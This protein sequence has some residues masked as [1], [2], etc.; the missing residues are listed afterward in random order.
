MNAF[1]EEGMGW[2]GAISGLGT[3]AYAIINMLLAQRRPSGQQTG[4]ARQVLRTPYLVVATMAFIV[5]GFVLWKQLPLHLP[6]TFRLGCSI[7]GEI[8]LL[9][10]LG[11]Y[12]WGLRNLGKNFNASS[13]FGVRLKKAHQLLTTGPF[14]YVRYPIYLAVILASWSGLMLLRTRTMLMMALMMF[15]LVY[16]GRKE[17][18]ALAQAFG[19]EWE[20][21]K[22]TVPGWLPW[23][24]IGRN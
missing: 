2:L 20:A 18:N 12:I 17:E 13:G 23:L 11:L 5:L 1:L 19:V 15:G 7:V 10:S 22:H 3:L 24:T 16:R 8:I 4:A 14:N 9:P 6:Q 21:Y